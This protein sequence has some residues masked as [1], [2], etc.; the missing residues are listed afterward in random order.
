MATMSPP[1]YWIGIKGYRVLEHSGNPPLRV[2]AEPE[3]TPKCC[4]HCGSRQLHSNVLSLAALR[5]RPD[6][7]PRNSE[8][9]GM[10]SSQNALPSAPC[11]SRC[12][13]K[14]SAEYIDLTP[15][16]YGGRVKIVTKQPLPPQSLIQLS[17]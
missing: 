16:C 7:S 13:K 15:F 6:A 17:V 1:T 8:N 3:E 11:T 5:K 2:V 9:G 4:V 14:G 10:N 12:T